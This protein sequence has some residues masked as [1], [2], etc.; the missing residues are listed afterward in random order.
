[1]PKPKLIRITTI[2]LS[3]EKLLE[4]QLDFMNSYF[5]VVAVSSNLLA[6]Q[7]VAEK[8][9]VRCFHIPLTRKITPFQDV[10][11]TFKLYRFLKK[12][13]PEIVHTH[14][15]K[16]GI[17]GMLAARMAGV[18]IRLHTIAGLPL[19]ETK[20]YKRKL[21]LWIERLTYTLATKVY[22]NSKGLQEF[23][24][25]EKLVTKAKLKVIGNG[26]SNG[27]N[28]LYFDPNSVKEED[29]N[30]LLNKIGATPGAFTFVFIGRMVKDKGLIELIEAFAQLHL[31]KNNIQLLLV[32]PMEQDLDPLSQELI[33]QMQAHPKIFFM[34][35][36]EDVRP[37]LRASDLLVFP[38]YREGFPNVVL[39]ALAMELPAIVTNINGCNE[40]ITDGWNGLVIP[41]RDTKALLTA[42]EFLLDNPII[43]QQ[44]KNKA[45]ASILDRFDQKALWNALYQEYQKLLEENKPIKQNVS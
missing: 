7:K 39:Q 24:L 45:R 34:G 37:F 29:K 5:E 43:Y 36:Q 30:Q 13:A 10:I 6:L 15:P 35:Y 41:K 44:L 4:G 2:P 18:P 27:I 25:Q 17:V 40:I 22:P 12:E 9:G 11:A 8:E 26:G 42:M 38:S 21:L 23:V 31:R 1:M 20:G 32:G 19:M 16:A 28:T 3:L 14:T 33:E